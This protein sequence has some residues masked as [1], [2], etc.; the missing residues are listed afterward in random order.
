[1][2]VCALSSKKNS[3]P[4]VSPVTVRLLSPST[5]TYFPLAPWIWN[6]PFVHVTWKRSYTDRLHSRMAELPFTPTNP[7]SPRRTRSGRLM[8][9]N[10]NLHSSVSSAES[11][12][13]LPFDFTETYFPLEPFIA[14][15][16]PCHSTSKRHIA[17]RVSL[18]AL[19]PGV[20]DQYFLLLHRKDHLTLP[21]LSS[22]LAASIWK[23]SLS[24]ELSWAWLARTSRP[25]RIDTSFPLEAVSRTCGWLS[26]RTKSSSLPMVSLRDCT[27]AIAP[28]AVRYL[29]LLSRKATCVLRNTIV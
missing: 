9:S 26:I 21:D 20:W 2:C 14:I 5:Q 19:I 23:I 10:T 27:V 17:S 22:R 28:T 7:Y 16:G 8:N 15:M 6:E 4:T 11:A 18:S 25:S 12:D 29:P 3:A 13:I 24:V 1:M